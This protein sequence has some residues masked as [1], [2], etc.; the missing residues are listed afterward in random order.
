MGNEETEAKVRFYNSLADLSDIIKENIEHEK[1]WIF[2][3]IEKEE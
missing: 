3:H 1:A 2:I